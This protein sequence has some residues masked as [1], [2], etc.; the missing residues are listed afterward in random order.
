MYR[1][2]ANTTPFYIRDLCMGGFWYLQGGSWNQC[3]GDAVGRL[4]LLFSRDFT[5]A[6]YVP[7]S[8]LGDMSST[9]PCSHG[10]QVL[11]WSGRGAEW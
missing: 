1:L 3:L 9:Q 10:A 6:H 2:Y 7:S 4:F 8:F 11:L 5:C